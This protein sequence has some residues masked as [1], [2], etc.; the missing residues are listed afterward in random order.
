MSTEGSCSCD[1]ALGCR[2]TAGCFRLQHSFLFEHIGEDLAWGQ[3]SSVEDLLDLGTDSGNGTMV[4][5]MLHVALPV[6]ANLH[7]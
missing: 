6:G 4:L 2:L 7:M 1:C 3:A 5:R